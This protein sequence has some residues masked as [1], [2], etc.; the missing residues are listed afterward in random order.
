FNAVYFP[1]RDTDT[2]SRAPAYAV[3]DYGRIMRV[4]D[5]SSDL[6]LY[7]FHQRSM[8]SGTGHLRAVCFPNGRQT[9]F[10][11]GDSGAILRTRRGGRLTIDFNEQ[12]TCYEAAFRTFWGDKANPQP[13]PWFYGFYWW[14]YRVC[15]T[16]REIEFEDWLSCMTPQQKP[17]REVLRSWFAAPFE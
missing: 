6:P 7:R 1:V 13:R 15:P 4:Q 5:L 9:G 12:A 10:A 14:F 11:V 8:P 16:P 17:A 3:G 2:T